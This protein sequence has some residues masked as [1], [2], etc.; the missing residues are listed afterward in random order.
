MSEWWTYRLG[1]FLMFSPRTYWRL[2]EAYH[3]ELWPVQ[4]VALAGGGAVLSLGAARWPRAAAV[5]LAAAWAWVAWRFHWERLATIHLAAPW[6]AA[7]G[8]LQ[9]GMLV[10]AAMFAADGGPAPSVTTRRAGWTVALA[11]VL[12]YPAA[13]AWIGASP[14]RAEAFGA[15]PEPTALATLGLLATG[16]LAVRRGAAWGLAILPALL[17]AAGGAT[18]WTMAQ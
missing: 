11:A 2:V 9:S 1:D 13:T 5:L 17:L 4:W 18:L 16:A 10:V 12:A 7:A 15:M 6:Y 8:A 3:R 14:W